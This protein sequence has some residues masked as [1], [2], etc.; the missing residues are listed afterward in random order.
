MQSVDNK[1][2]RDLLDDLYTEF[3]EPTT[4][5]YKTKDAK[6]KDRIILDF[7][8]DGVTVAFNIVDEIKSLLPGTSKTGKKKVIVKGRPF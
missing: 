1:V 4:E 7:M 6:E 3:V 5:Q 8:G 2:V